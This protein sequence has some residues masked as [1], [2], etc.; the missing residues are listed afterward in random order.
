MSARTAAAALLVLAGCAAP[1]SGA[2]VPAE[3]AP[4]GHSEWAA[5]CSDADE[6]DRPGPPFRIH[7]NTYYVGTCGIAAI[8]VAGGPQGHVLIDGGTGAAPPLIAANIAALGLRIE[9]VALLLSSHEH[10]DHVGGLAD[11]QRRSGARLLASPAAAP[12][13]AS[14]ETAADDPQAGMHEPFEAARVD[15]LVIAGEPLRLGSLS[16]MALPTPGH[17]LGALSWQWE[18][19]DGGDCRTIVYA[20][21]LSPISNDSYR[22]S[23]H[24]DLVAAYR[25][26]LAR[27]ATLDCD[28][29]M[30]PH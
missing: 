14:G 16:L 28:I 27:L 10:F 24:P 2:P 21:S 17:T 29:L 8:L 22:F 9:D 19:C 30:T 12:V 3:I 5:T 7:G 20:D 4:T 25:T 1:P 26:G 13:L 18:S 23:D 11:L 6:W 15:G